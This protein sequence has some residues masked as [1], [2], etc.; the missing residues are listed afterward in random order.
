MPS[1]WRA[2]EAGPITDLAPLT[3]HYDVAVVGAGLMGLSTAVMPARHGARVIVL[4]AREVGAGT[5]GGSTAKISLLQGTRLSAIVSRHPAETVAQ[6]VAGN[7]VGAFTSGSAHEAAGAPKGL[8]HNLHAAANVVGPRAE[9]YA[10]PAGDPEEGSGVVGREGAM[11]VARARVGGRTHEVSASC[12]HL[13]G[14][15]SWNDAECTWDCSLHGS[16][17]TATGELRE[18]P[19]TTG[20]SSARLGLA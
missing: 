6:Y 14:V 8:S 5:T 13:G 16:R 3:R 7:R 12:P 15:L 17:S 2:E 11:L 20:M 9:G 19:A 18:G 10:R 4:E 1:P